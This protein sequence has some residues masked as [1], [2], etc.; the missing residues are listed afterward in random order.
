MN[1]E[2]VIEPYCKI[3]SDEF[4]TTLSCNQKFF[5]LSDGLIYELFFDGLIDVAILLFL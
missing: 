5:N 1:F 2:V 3:L 4:R